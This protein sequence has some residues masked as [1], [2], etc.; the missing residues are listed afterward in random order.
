MSSEIQEPEIEHQRKIN[1]EINKKS[2]ETLKMAL[3]SAFLILLLVIFVKMISL[4]LPR[5]GNESQNENFNA[6]LQN[7]DQISQMSDKPISFSQSFDFRF[8]FLAPFEF[9]LTAKNSEDAEKVFDYLRLVIHNLVNTIEPV[10]KKI[11]ADLRFSHNS[12]RYM[13]YLCFGKEGIG[14]FLTLSHYNFNTRINKMSTGRSDIDF[15]L[16][17][18]SRY[19]INYLSSREVVTPKNNHLENKIHEI[20]VQIQYSAF[21]WE[22]KLKDLL[23]IVIGI[24][25]LSFYESPFLQDALLLKQSQQALEE[26]TLFKYQNFHWSFNTKKMIEILKE[27][28][29]NSFESARD[30]MMSLGKKEE[31]IL[32]Y[33]FPKRTLDQ[34][35][36][37]QRFISGQKFKNEIKKL[38]A[39]AD[40]E[41]RVLKAGESVKDLDEEIKKFLEEIDNLFLD[42]NLNEARDEY[43]RSYKGNFKEI[44]KSLN[45]FWE[46]NRTTF[47]ELKEAI[48]EKAMEVIKMILVFSYY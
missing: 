29:E 32:Y 19:I 5:K 36:F 17:A 48:K 35:E 26:S 4:C 10:W 16:T 6:D 13:L 7:I 42:K 31:D 11:E 1:S 27:K 21:E 33:C 34:P 25:N 40:F 24:H 3:G 15:N 8:E 9:D 22:Q 30:S 43:K 37:F 12:V 39:E 46:N 41:K 18:L 14:Q 45:K 38:K 2:S 20:E 44:E 23:S 28:R 47:E